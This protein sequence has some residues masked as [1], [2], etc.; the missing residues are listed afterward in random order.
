MRELPDKLVSALGLDYLQAPA[1][2]KSSTQS[3][4]QVFAIVV[5]LHWVE[6]ELH[7]HLNPSSVEGQQDGLEGNRSFCVEKSV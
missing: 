7:Y 1:S 3:A 2:Y 4:L 5:L 6:S